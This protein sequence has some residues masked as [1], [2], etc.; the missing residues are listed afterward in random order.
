MYGHYL[1]FD[2]HRRRTYVVTMDEPGQVQGQRRLANEA[3]ADD[4]PTLPK[5]S[6]AV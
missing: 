5:N 2:L 1:G 6:L 4:V 3:L